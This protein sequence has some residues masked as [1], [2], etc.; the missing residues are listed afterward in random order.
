MLWS[1]RAAEVWHHERL[2]EG[3][4]EYAVSAEVDAPGLKRSWGE[5]EG[6]RHV[7][8]S[9]S[10]KRVQKGPLV[11]ILALVANPTFW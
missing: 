7:A 10:L 4:V 9:D 5:V 11:K 6:W 8:M 1:W 3:M 2:G